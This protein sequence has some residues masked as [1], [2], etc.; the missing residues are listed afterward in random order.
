MS[1]QVKPYTVVFDGT[2]A[3]PMGRMLYGPESPTEPIQA[4]PLRPRRR[5]VSIRLM[6]EEALQAGPQT[7]AELAAVLG[8][9]R[10]E[11]NTGVYNGIKGGAV[12]VVGLRPRTGRPRFGRR[13]AEQVYGL[14]GR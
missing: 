5:P 10:A 14:V 11:A 1:E 9:T 3:A 13:T 7:A 2:A 8:L 6:V 4:E 12:C